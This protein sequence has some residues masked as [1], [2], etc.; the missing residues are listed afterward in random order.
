MGSFSDRSQFGRSV[1]LIPAPEVER[2]R[3]PLLIRREAGSGASAMPN[4]SAVF[5]LCPGVT[6]R[7]T[8]DRA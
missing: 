3:A 6:G 8:E 7:R 1:T 5:R 2:L 4:A